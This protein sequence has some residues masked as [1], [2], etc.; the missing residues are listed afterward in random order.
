MADWS[1]NLKIE[2][3]T[4]GTESGTW[5]TVTNTNFENVLEQ[6]IVGLGDVDFA[7]DANT[8]I[9]L[10]NS[11]SLQAARCL[12]LNV[13]ST[14][15]LTAT[16]ELVVPTIEKQYIVQ[17][18]T[19][20]SQSI[21]VKTSGGS[22]VTIPNG[23]KAHLYVDGTNVIQ[24]FDYFGSLKVGSSLTVDTSFVMNGQG[25]SPTITLTDASTIA[26]DVALGQV[27]KVTLTASGH[28]VGAPSNIQDGA[29]YSLMVIQDGTGSRTVSWNSAFKWPDGTA[30][31]LSTAAAS[32]DIFTF[33]SNGT[34]LYNVGQSLNLS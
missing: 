29:F 1:D 16:R 4:T 24:M 7:T 30:P 33:R 5:G 19:T 31:T 9:S 25:Y 28:T 18:N 3:M 27:A 26:W 11:T 32:I 13:T 34:N 12:V 14:G 2:L 20:G 23:R 6:S 22:G 17:N 8:S 21:T 10:S 15:S